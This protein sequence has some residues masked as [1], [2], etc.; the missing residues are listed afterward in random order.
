MKASDS[1][2]TARIDQSRSLYLKSF[3]LSSFTHIIHALPYDST[4]T[5]TLAHRLLTSTS[6]QKHSKK[7]RT[8]T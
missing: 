2:W 5:S 7:Y 4:L 1:A 3:I 8:S 6:V